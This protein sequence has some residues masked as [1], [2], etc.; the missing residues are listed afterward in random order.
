MV[1]LTSHREKPMDRLTRNAIAADLWAFKSLVTDKR[2]IETVRWNLR[3]V[4]PLET[5]KQLY[6][7]WACQ[8]YYRAS[9]R[10]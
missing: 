4:G 3:E 7:D 9:G 8:A 6:R 5:A 10:A 1:G 2:L